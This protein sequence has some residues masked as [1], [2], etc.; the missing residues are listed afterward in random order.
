MFGAGDVLD[1]YYAAFRIP[2]FIF[3]LLAVGAL[4]AGFIP[5]F[6]KLLQ[7]NKDEAWKIANGVFNCVLILLTAVCAVL[8]VFAPQLTKYVVPG[9]AP[10]KLNFTINLTR[11]MLL[12]PVLLG[13]SSVFNSVLQSFKNFL[14]FS[15]TPI[16][17]NLGI[18]FGALVLVPYFGEI[19]LAYGVVLGSLLHL[20]IQIPSLRYH[21][22]KYQGVLMWRDESVR[23]IGKLII[24]RTLG[25]AVGQ[26]NLLVTTTIAST[27]I[28]GSVAIFNL[29]NNL[30]FF[31]VGIIGVSF[32]VAA[33]PTL[34]E[35]AVQDKR[36]EMIDS[37]SRTIRQVLFFIV[38]LTIVFLI[39][40][41]QIVRV[42]LGSGKF[43]WTDT[44]TT[45][46]ALA[47]FSLSLFAQSLFYL[48]ARAFYALRDTVTPL[49]IAAISAGLNIILSLYLKNYLDVLGLALAFSISA[50][51]QMALLWIML[52]L[53]LHSLH[54]SKILLSLYKISV[55]G[56]VMAII[57]Q[58][59]KTPLSHWVDMTKFWG[60]LTQGAVAGIIGL[61]VYWFICWLLRLEEMQDFLASAKRKWLKLQN[62]PREVE[63]NK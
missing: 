38:P 24:P 36:E 52:R 15:I 13:L 55:A 7:K 44:I 31:A 25:L 43:D 46:D 45:A 53:R 51:M 9:F 2:D 34:S 28:A 60:I 11:V 42:V 48:L 27:L 47:F 29:A 1:A 3:N 49:W 62:V 16:M 63:E 8:F 12:S 23:E 37:L 5:V 19:G 14:I 18:I 33:F 61:L 10:D 30:Q 35:L 21:G 6:T 54:E 17:Y 4:S 40:R 26:I 50:I 41:A 57:T 56:I 22:Y 39:L 59:L 20:I 58:I 32:A